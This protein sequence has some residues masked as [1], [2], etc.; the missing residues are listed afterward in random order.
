[1][2]WGPD[3]ED[4]VQDCYSRLLAKGDEYDLPRDGQKLLFK[5]ITNACINH[6][7]RRRPLVSLDAVED[8]REGTG[9]GAWLAD[10]AEADPPDHASHRELTDAVGAAL[11]ELPVSQRAVVELRSLGHPLSEIAGMLEIS[12]ANARVL[13][14]RARRALAARLRPFLEETGG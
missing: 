2:G 9:R 3:A 14:H 1:V 4:I 8:D 12:H 11:G 6:V 10:R 5:S 7:Q 13:L